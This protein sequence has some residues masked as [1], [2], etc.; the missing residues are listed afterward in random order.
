MAKL[1]ILNDSDC[2]RHPIAVVQ[3]DVTVLIFR[4]GSIVREMTVF[5]ALESC[6]SLRMGLYHMKR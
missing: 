6:S 2:G 4:Q 5:A 3:E 1:L